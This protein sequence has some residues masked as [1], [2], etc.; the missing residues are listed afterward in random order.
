MLQKTKTKQK[1]ILWEEINQ[2]QTTFRVGSSNIKIA[3]QGGGRI[4]L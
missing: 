4:T 1:K 3:Q 2:Q